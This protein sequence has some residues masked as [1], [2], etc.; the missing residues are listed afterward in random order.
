LKFVYDSKIILL[1]VVQR[2]EIQIANNEQ[3]T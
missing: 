1:N 3:T 2:K